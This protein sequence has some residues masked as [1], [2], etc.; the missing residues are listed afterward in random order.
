FAA[1]ER[2]GLS[3]TAFGAAL[4]VVT[5]GGDVLAD[6]PY[7]Q[8]V[9]AYD[10]LVATLA[11]HPELADAKKPSGGDAEKRAAWHLSRGELD[12]AAKLLADPKSP[13]ACLLEARLLRRRHEIEPALAALDAARERRR[14]VGDLALE[15]DLE[16]VWL[17]LARGHVSP[18][19]NLCTRIA[20][21][22]V[23]QEDGLTAAY[24]LGVLDWFADDR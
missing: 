18:A 5:P 2:Y 7:W 1:Q 10:F 19:R 8:P 23:N 6:S 13:R 9:A 15:I 14:E 22:R 4:L 12:E 21:A 3:A 17:E 11:A 16:Q 20:S 24:L